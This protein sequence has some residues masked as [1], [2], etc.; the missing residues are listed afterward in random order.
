MRVR[1]TRDRVQAYVYVRIVCV[2]IRAFMHP[3]KHVARVTRV[4][5]CR[6]VQTYTVRDRFFSSR[7]RRPTSDLYVYV[8]TQTYLPPAWQGEPLD[9]VGKISGRV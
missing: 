2:L 3:A 9:R 8:R 7:A 4:H 1:G 6:R 5:V